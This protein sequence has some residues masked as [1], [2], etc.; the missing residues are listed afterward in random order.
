MEQ[1]TNRVKDI[2]RKK[3][4]AMS[5]PADGHDSWSVHISP[6]GLLG[7]LVAFCIFLF[8]LVLILVA[9]TPILDIFPGYR[10][11]AERSHD[12]LVE[13]IMRV[14]SLERRMNY[15]LVYSENVAMIMDGRTPVA[16]AKISE[17]DTVKLDKT[18][19][20]PSTLDSLLR[21]QMEGEGDYSLNKTIKS[22]SVGGGSRLF[23]SPVEG[24]ITR[25]FSRED[26]YLGIGIQATPN[27]PVTSIDE[28]TV[29]DVA[30]NNDMGTT[31]TVQHFDGYISVYR[32]LTQ[33]LVDKGQTIKS[34]QVIGYNS[35]P[36]VGDASN[37]IF[38]MEIWYEGKA[39]DP[40]IYIVF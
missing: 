6:A 4:L 36:Q 37:P 26:N 3:R 39:V 1:Q 25:H 18:F 20:A 38:E 12:A 32:N 22:Q 23:V 11:A 27:A 2:F 5:N 28:G 14:D 34:R 31:V 15:M 16:R 29:I 9:Y 33:V 21:A 7:S 40:E 30:S 19:V 13:G 24:I 17:S 10:T 35:M 8:L